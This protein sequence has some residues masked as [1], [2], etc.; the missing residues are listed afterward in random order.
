MVPNAG[1]FIRQ[2]ERKKE[3]KKEREKERKKERKKGNAKSLFL[4]VDNED[5]VVGQPDKVYISVV[6]ADSRSDPF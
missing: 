5:R 1:L 4:L 2:R 6:E 3:R